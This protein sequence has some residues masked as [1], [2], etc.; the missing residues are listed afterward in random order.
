MLVSPPELPQQQLPGGRAAA[1]RGA[2]GDREV[3]M[4]LRPQGREEQVCGE[5]VSVFW[6]SMVSNDP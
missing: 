5:V 2:H 6:A 1:Q 3:V 4:P